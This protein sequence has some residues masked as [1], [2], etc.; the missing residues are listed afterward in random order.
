MNE[1]ELIH[2][3]KQKDQAAFRQL[4]EVYEGKVYNTAIGFLRTEEDAEDITQEVF[5]EVFRSVHNFKGE[6]TLSTWVYRITVTKSL[7]LIRRKKQKKRF[8]FITNLFNDQGEENVQV[9][10]MVHPGVKLENKEK[11]QVLFSAIDRLPENQRVAFVMHKVEG[12]SYLEIAGVMDTSLSSVESLM[13][14]AKKNLQKYLYGYYK[15]Q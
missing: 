10:D 6:S 15:N 8:G 9:T 7:E 14:R 4:V 5:I 2:G 13:F 3:L 11:A 1:A 12:L